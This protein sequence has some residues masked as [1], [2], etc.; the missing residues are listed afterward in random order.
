VIPSFIRRLEAADRDSLRAQRVRTLLVNV[1][2]RCDLEC[3]HCHLSC[4]PHRIETMSAE[5]MDRVVAY[6]A[7][8]RPELVDIT[9][10][11]PELHPGLPR[12]IEMLRARDLDVQMRTNLTALRSRSD[13]LLEILADMDVRILAS[14]PGPYDSEWPGR[15]PALWD[16]CVAM[17]QELNRRGWGSADPRLDVAWTAPVVSGAVGLVQAEADLRRRLASHDVAF[18]ALVRIT[19]VPVGRFAESRGEGTRSYLHSLVDAFEPATARRLGCRHGV[20][21][22][23]DGSLWDC[24]FNL[25][26][27]VAPPKGLRHMDAVPAASLHGRPIAFGPHCYACTAAAGSS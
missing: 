15:D 8:L 5:R 26:A 17:L 25:A 12:F 11:A 22:A 14:I 18:D 13:G 19:D 21:I 24:D 23:W 7:E 6:A 2:L 4:S 20:E 3:A 1:G 9:G 10:G 16:T 27:E